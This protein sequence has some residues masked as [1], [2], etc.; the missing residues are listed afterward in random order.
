MTADS[1]IPYSIYHK[2]DLR[3]MDSRQIPF[4][5]IGAPLTFITLGTALVAAFNSTLCQRIFRLVG[6]GRDELD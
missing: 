3:N 1:S 5:A 6:Q 4:W 2:S